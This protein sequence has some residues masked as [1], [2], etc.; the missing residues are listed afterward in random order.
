[1]LRVV[2]SSLLSFLLVVTLLWGGC[3][4]CPQ[5]FM[6]QTAEKSCCNKAGQCERPSKTAPVKECKQ[7]PLEAH[8]FI[9]LAVDFSADNL[10]L[11]AGAAPQLTAAHLEAPAGA[12]SPPDLT[13]LNSSFL[14]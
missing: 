5:F 1:M 12:P 11:S 9:S 10:F 13:I 8:S 7:M 2:S 4:S 14:I 6:L 3:I